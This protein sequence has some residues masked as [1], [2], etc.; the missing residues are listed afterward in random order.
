MSRLRHGKKGKEQGG[1]DVPEV[2]FGQQFFPYRLGSELRFNYIWSKMFHLNGVGDGHAILMPWP[3]PMMKH[4][5]NV[6]NIVPV[7]LLKTPVGYTHTIMHEETARG[8]GFFVAVGF[9]DPQKANSHIFC[10]LDVGSSKL[11][12]QNLHRDHPQIAGSGMFVS[13]WSYPLTPENLSR[14]FLLHIPVVQVEPFMQ[15]MSLKFLQ[16]DRPGFY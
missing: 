14:A 8:Y 16:T 4:L 15:D 10:E 12:A 1:R 7:S 11:L 5:I 2:D 6:S 9:D 3:D 13:W